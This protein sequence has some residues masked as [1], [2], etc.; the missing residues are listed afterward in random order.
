M[1]QHSS[2]QR[3]SVLFAITVVAIAI[4]P[5][6]AVEFNLNN[7]YNLLSNLNTTLLDPNDIL[8]RN[9]RAIGYSYS[10][11]L[12][13]CGTG[14]SGQNFPTVIQQLSLWFLPYLILLAQIPFQ[15]D[16]KVGDIIALILTVGSPMLALYS[17]FLTLSTWKWLRNESLDWLG[18]GNGESM[19]QILPEVLGRLQQ[20]PVVVQNLDLLASALAIPENNGWW[21]TLRD[22]LRSR[23]RRLDI[24]GLAQLFLAGLV[25]I[26]AVV[27]ALARLGGKSF[28]AHVVDFQTVA[29]PKVWLSVTSS[30]GSLPWFG[31]GLQ[32]Q[33][34]SADKTQPI[35]CCKTEPPIYG[36]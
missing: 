5:I 28:K 17:L 23:E 11:C 14:V 24:S 8:F 12:E 9:G 19:V 20:Y 13:V 33:L 10:T 35:Y 2:R 36:L 7:C 21:R 32:S 1:C 27:E 18:I 15:T 26:F 4:R 22:S 3:I 30:A 25:Y 31:A 6:A 16:D 29:P 34:N